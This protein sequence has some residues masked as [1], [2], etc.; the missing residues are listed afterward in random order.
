MR[1]IVA[2][3]GGT[4]R[5]DDV[6]EPYNEEIIRLSGKKSPNFLFLAHA[7]PYNLETQEAGFQ[8]MRK[9]FGGLYGC[10]CRDLK[11]N[12]LDNAEKVKSLADW[13]DIIYEGGGNTLDMIKIWR[14]KGF[15][16]ILEK[17]WEDGK[18]M[19]GLSA[20]ANC[21][22]RECSTD[23]LQILYGPDAPLVGMEAL[24]FVDGFFVPHCDEP[25]RYESVKE[26]LKENDIVGISMS[27]G[28]ALE[29]VD[30]KYRLITGDT[31][32]TKGFDAYGLKTYWKN[33][34]Y[35]EKSIEKSEKFISF[36]ELLKRD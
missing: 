4:G 11:I 7:Q 26:I 25:G 13:A 32:E 30:G 14:E 22:F 3:G 18:V 24:G 19:C 21:W 2:I 29:I 28:A 31:T 34:E 1:K 33:G 6:S 9:I 27:N 16:K 8:Q 20:G 17:A 23:S 36:E 5:K 35:V 12:E 10:S 15:D